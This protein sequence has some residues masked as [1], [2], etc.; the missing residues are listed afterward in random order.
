MK[1]AIIAVGTPITERPPLRSG[2]ARFGHPAPILSQEQN[3]S[4]TKPGLSGLSPRPSCFC[5]QDRRVTRGRWPALS[6]RTLRR[7]S[8]RGDRS[9]GP[10][11]HG[12][13][14]LFSSIASLGCR[15]ARNACI[16]ND[17][18]SILRSKIVRLDPRRQTDPETG[19]VLRRDTTFL[20][21]RRSGPRA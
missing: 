17:Q 9:G 3:A 19:W 7:V 16:V 15:G 4:L 20:R 11:R 1:M 2:R 14:A 18:W 8:Y 6:L 13:P 10:F 21:Q 12:K 5:W